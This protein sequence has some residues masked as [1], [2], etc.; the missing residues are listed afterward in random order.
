MLHKLKLLRK[1]NH[2]SQQ[3]LAAAVGVS[4][5]S[6]NKYENHDVETD[7]STLIALADYF[8]VSVDFLIDHFPNAS[9]QES[10]LCPS[11]EEI[12]LICKYRLLS[13]SEKASIDLILANYIR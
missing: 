9:V 6:I 11:G 8:H 3:Q 1:R 2:I 4:Q 10:T 5:Q 13:P 12:D 7:L